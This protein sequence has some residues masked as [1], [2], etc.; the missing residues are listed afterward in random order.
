MEEPY[1]ALSTILPSRPPGDR[2]RIGLLT[3]ALTITMAPRVGDTDF[4]RLILLMT[5]RVFYAS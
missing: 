1:A 2:K 5:F 4:I 3:P